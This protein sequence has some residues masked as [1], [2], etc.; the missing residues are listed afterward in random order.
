MRML[1]GLL[2]C[3]AVVL[4]SV[5]AQ[6]VEGTATIRAQD[7]YSLAQRKTYRLGIRAG[8]ISPTAS[9][10]SS[11]YDVTL[12]FDAK[13]NENLDTGPRF[14]L[15][16]YQVTGSD[17]VSVAKIG[18]GARMYLTYWGDY[19]SSHGFVNVYID[20]QADYY[21]GQNVSG[22]GGYGGAGL[23]LAFGPNATGYA[24]A[25]YQKIS[26][27]VPLDGILIQVG[28]RLAFI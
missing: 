26:G 28:T 22:F 5:P 7:L 10:V 8:Y 23:E 18:Y 13:L 14:G 25:A 6:A 9:T 4:T 27:E 2:V 12:E 1:L 21:T 3:L 15:A 20:G 16:Y 17:A 11:A 19:G 24:C